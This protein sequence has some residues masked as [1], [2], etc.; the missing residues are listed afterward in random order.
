MARKIIVDSD[1]GT[2]DAIAICM[3]LF[4][5]DLEVLALTACEGCVSAVQANSNL[6]AILAELD[7]DRY[8]RLG[9]AS[10]TANAPPI[11]S[12]YLYGDD[13]L[14]N[15]NFEISG[16][17]HLLPAEKVIIE[18]IRMNPGEVTFVGLGPATNLAKALRRDPAIEEMIGQVIQ[19]GGSVTGMGNITPAA[20]FNFYFDPESARLVLHSRTTKLL[21]PLD[22]TQQL[23]FGLDLFEYLPE[24][25]SRVGYFCR[26]ILPFAFRAYRQRLGKEMITLNDAVGAL[27]VIKADLFEFT[28]MAGDVEIEGELTRGAVVFDRR[29]LPEWRMNVD[30]ATTIDLAKARQT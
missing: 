19:I 30:V 18:C 3:L 29:V 11:N 15:S 1:M 9:M 22:I 2:D 17:Q 16:K 10:E 8:P 26:Q 24:E 23:Q 14:G 13:G 7:P 20:E 4:H 27:A 12:S 5:P 21:L 6:Q 25:G 28:R